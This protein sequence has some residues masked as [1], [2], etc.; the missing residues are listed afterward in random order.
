[1]NISMIPLNISII[2]L[3]IS[4]K[5]ITGLLIITF[6]ICL[7]VS[8]GAQLFY[9]P[10]PFFYPPVPFMPFAPIAPPALRTT[11]FMGFSGFL[12]SPLL[13]PV[14]AFPSPMVRRANTTIT[15]WNTVGH[16]TYLLIY[17]PTLLLGPAAAPITPSPLLSL[18]AGQ[19]LIFGE[20]ALST[21]NPALFNYLVNT[22]L[23]PTGL[24][25]YFF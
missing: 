6:I 12:R 10:V 15:I 16:T 11:P 24:A 4:L 17:N 2:P 22:Y 14:P 18:L 8:A 21:A 1:M 9:P 25:L 5:Y 13:P 20:S 23:L 3:K 7:S 19:L